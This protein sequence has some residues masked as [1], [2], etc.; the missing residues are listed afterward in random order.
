MVSHAD[1]TII[2]YDR[3]REDS[4]F[5][6]KDPGVNSA[7]SSSSAPN[8]PN[9]TTTSVVDPSP[10]TNTSSS[11]VGGPGSSLGS[12]SQS[13]D[14]YEWNPIDEILVSPGPSAPTQ[15]GGVP[16]GKEKVLRNPVSH[17]RISRK[18]ING[19]HPNRC[20]ALT[21]TMAYHSTDNI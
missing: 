19:E 6:P 21:S 9:G 2:V 4:N 15:N 1:G 11:N 10:G 18:G 17:W 3:E 13:G 16:V 8:A 20:F 5:V 7:S 14:A 12:Q